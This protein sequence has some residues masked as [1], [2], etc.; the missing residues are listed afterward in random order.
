M[1]FKKRFKKRFQIGFKIGFK[2][3]FRVVSRGNT[4]ESK[5]KQG[6]RA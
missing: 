6:F 5:E 4:L 1:G 3:G 2:I